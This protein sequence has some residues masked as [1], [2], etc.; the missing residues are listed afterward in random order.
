[1]TTLRAAAAFLVFLSAVPVMAMKGIVFGASGDP[2]ASAGVEAFATSDPATPIASATT[3]AKGLFTLDLKTDAA[4]FVS[5]TA[6][7]HAPWRR[8]VRAQADDVVIQLSAADS[9]TGLVR[10]GKGPVPGAKILTFDVMEDVVATY[11][12]DDHGRFSMPD[13]QR[14]A[15]AVCVRHPD[16]AVKCRFTGDMRGDVAD[17][18]D[19]T[20]EAGKLV[21]GRVLSP[22][23]KPVANANVNAGR[24]TTSTTRDDGSFALRVSNAE[25]TIRATAGEWTGMAPISGGGV[26]IQL[27][28]GRRITGTV[29]DTSGR[30]IAGARVRAQDPEDATSYGAAAVS[31]R[32]EYTITP[33]P[34]TAYAVY[35]EMPEQYEVEGKRGDLRKNVESRVDFE[36]KKM[37]LV[38]GIVRDED[39][40]PV[41]GAVIAQ[42][43]DGSPLIYAVMKN[44]TSRAASGPDGTFKL[45]AV[46]PQGRLT[47]IKHGFAIGV[48][49]RLTA[50]SLLKPVTITLPHGLEV[51]GSV[52]GP[53]EKPMGDARI[54]IMSADTALG[55]VPFAASLTSGFVDEWLRADADGTFSVRLNR[56]VHEF[57]VSKKG[58]ASTELGGVEV[59]ESMQPVR[60]VLEQGVSIRGRVSRKSGKPVDGGMVFANEQN[61]RG[62]GQ[63]KVGNNGEFVIESLQRGTYAL[64][65][66]NEKN[67]RAAKT[68]EAP[69]VDVV[70]E[71]PDTFEV[72]GRVTDS[73]TGAPIPR[74][75][76]DV[77]GD[78]VDQIED[79]RGEFVESLPA[80]AAEVRVSAPGYTP[81][82]QTILISE[83]KTP[84]PLAFSLVKGRRISGRVVSTEGKPLPEVMIGSEG[85][86]NEG[87]FDSSDSSMTDE[88]GAF[89]IEGA[90]LENL[91]L[92]FNKDGFVYGRKKVAA[93]AEDQT[94]EVILSSGRR[95][96]GRVADKNGE[97]VDEAQITASGDDYQRAMTDKS[98]AFTISGLGDGPYEITA[99]KSGL[100]QAKVKDVDPKK[101]V[102]L[103]LTLG[104]N[105]IGTIHGTLSGT[106]KG[107]WMMAMVTATSE[108]GE[109]A[110][111]QV[112][113]DG[114]FVIENVPAG[115]VT[116]RGM[117]MSMQR[118]SSTKEVKVVVPNGG[119]VEVQLA[120]TAG[121]IILRGTVKMA[122]QPAPGSTVMFSSQSGDGQWTLPTSSDGTYEVSG[123]SP[124]R[125]SVSVWQ[126][127]KGGAYSM[128]TDLTSSTTL[129]IDAT[130]VRIEGRVVDERGAGI[131]G[132]S[133]SATPASSQHSNVE[134]KTDISGAFALSVQGDMAYRIAASKKTFA[135]ATVEAP[136]GSPGPLL[137][138]LHH[139]E[140]AHV[141]VV[142]SQTGVTLNGFVVVRDETGKIQFPTSGDRE[143]DGSLLLPLLE[144]SYRVSASA[145]EY[146]SQT[147]R[148][149]VPSGA[150][151]IPLSRGGTLVV[152]SADDAHELIKLVMPNGEE[153]VRC[154]CNG[155]AEIRLSG[156]MTTVDHVAAGA[157]RMLVIDEHEVT[158]R[159]YP[160]VI[161]EGQTTT[162]DATK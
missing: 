115:E 37:T 29:R 89:T 76:L 57:G 32:G 88:D 140:G 121:D 48:S 160:I 43:V 126:M 30:A 143:D 33:L 110:Q 117:L 162:V 154:Y 52:V 60:I 155:I 150:T 72:K 22:D 79:T 3:D 55:T 106:S 134:A 95:V 53:D 96:T 75:K 130:F 90:P 112:G 151:T 28:K 159:S 78:V 156:A 146:A 84:E 135:I 8:I 39:R 6:S 91:V 158:K 25:K 69:A 13:P 128:Q 9:K 157:Y 4:V 137:L 17:F 26:T 38:R 58:F 132:A 136:A 131:E 124:G 45:Y 11:E 73:A 14:W 101:T 93:G 80:G 42:A 97:P 98:G 107:A 81:M 104:T 66:M 71:L 94:I 122:G 27:A 87:F 153:Y 119:D 20:L 40:R 83:T 129:D 125:Y 31:V 142:D 49:E 77:R 123:L 145:N 85:K 62:A 105:G 111:A 99:T 54:I 103:V 56:G 116:V 47:A 138:Q 149:S 120:A 65:F 16:F 114:K 44:D 109:G 92:T 100:G 36:A 1:M 67:A 141:R 46:Q 23:G 15:A 70:L 148:L 2:L 12:S 63:A 139:T 34:A 152:R 108:E 24:F 147:I 118:Q 19:V 127:G 59:S 102:P 10:S 82:S 74:F 113:R 35:V 86:G 18:L 64:Q 5:A 41:A 144:G 68:T 7:G 51:K 50:T 161:T 133:V 61:Q 21:S